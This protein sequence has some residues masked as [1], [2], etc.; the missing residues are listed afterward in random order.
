MGCQWVVYLLPRAWV[1]WFV[2]CVLGPS[3]GLGRVGSRV[4]CVRVRWA[5]AR[6]WRWA[7]AS[8]RPGVARARLERVRARM[9][10]SRAHAQRPRGCAR[11]ARALSPY[12]TSLACSPSAQRGACVRSDHAGHA[13]APPHAT[14]AR[15]RAPR[16]RSRPAPAPGGHEGRGF[17]RAPS[18]LETWTKETAVSQKFSTMQRSLQDATAVALRFTAFLGRERESTAFWPTQILLFRFSLRYL[19]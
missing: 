5:S 13:T 6:A 12:P 16:L 11:I 7:R 15:P 9:A 3:R 4:V 19:M 1:G 2:L 18:P 10:S 17:A 14:A 8:V